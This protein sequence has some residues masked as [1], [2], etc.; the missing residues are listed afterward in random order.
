M[1]LKPDVLVNLGDQWDFPSLSSYD[2]GKAS[3]H[4]R[5]YNK[6]LEAGLEFTDR[7]FA[8]MKRAK[9]K[10]PH[11]VFLVGNH[12]QRIERVLEQHSELEG[13]IGYDKLDLKRHYDDVVHYKGQ[14]PGSINIDGV[15]YAH[16]FVTGVSGRGVSGE[17][18]AYSL[19]TKQF[20]SATMGHSHTFDYSVRTDATGR[21]IHGLVAG[22]F[23]G[24][25][26]TWAGDICRLWT[27][28]LVIK[29]DVENGDYDLEFVSLKRLE[30]IYGK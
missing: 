22:V 10:K 14:T 1:D 25:D 30:S 6:D 20:Q 7:M 2:K 24:Y 4:G 26:S 27:R 17:H 28:G 3:F 9:K 13:T 11:T 12:E 21:R 19:L 29:R 5:S 8:P 15:S 16:F 18:P 23:Q